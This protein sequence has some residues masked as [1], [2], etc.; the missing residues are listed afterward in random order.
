MQESENWFAKRNF[1]TRR[2]HPQNAPQTGLLP[3]CPHCKAKIQNFSFEPPP[4]AWKAGTLPLSYSRETRSYFIVND[5][6]CQKENL[7]LKVF[8]TSSFLS[9]YGIDDLCSNHSMHGQ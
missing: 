8:L 3:V 2:K 5:E 9:P 7:F 6:A 1:F 4:P